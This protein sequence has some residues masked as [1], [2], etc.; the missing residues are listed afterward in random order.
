MSDRL[1]GFC[2]VAVAAVLWGL[3]VF[4][5]RPAGL[6]GF[7]SGAIMFSVLAV[8]GIPSMWRG[9]RQ[10]HARRAWLWLAFA[11]LL[12]AGN[13]GCYFT[14]LNRG[15]IATAVL[16]HYLAPTFAPLFAWLL[17]RERLSPRTLPAAL[18]GLA[19]LGALLWPAGGP[20]VLGGALWGAAS[21]VCYGGLFP[22]GKRLMREFSAL[23]VMGYHSVVS[24]V[25]LALLAP[26]L[27]APLRSIAWV[28]A[29][30]L[31]CA[32]VAGM[33]F[34]RGLSLV[35]AG[36]AS[37]LTYL[38]PLTATLAGAL[39]FGERIGPMALLGAA[40]V[41]AGGLLLVLE[42]GRLPEAA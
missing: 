3:W 24:A 2:C 15:T 42:P 4:F 16:S 26:P 8:A 39:A 13:A 37:T 30:A 1:L 10:V 18:I 41:L 6:P 33:L 27:E 28:A 34:Y 9:R 21:A 35:P 14:A 20:P 29:G 5:L 38:E 31:L 12:D 40:L 25:F 22:V 23:E 11:G 17:L 36:Q 32:V 19:G 7:T